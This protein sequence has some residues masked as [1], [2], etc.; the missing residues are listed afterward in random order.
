MVALDSEL[1][2]HAANGLL[3]AINYSASLQTPIFVPRNEH[4]FRL[5]LHSL[6]ISRDPGPNREAIKNLEDSVA[7]D[8]EYAPA[9]EEL[10]WR[11]YID[12]TYGDGGSQERTRGTECFKKLMQLDPN[13]TANQITIKTENGNLEGAYDEAADLL[14]RWPDKSGPHYEMS[15]VLR[16]AGLL[17]E[18]KKECAAALA[19]DPGYSAYR[20]CAI[21]F[22]LSGD[23]GG[24][25][26][27]IGLDQNT[28]F[29]AMLRL[30]IALRAGNGAA[31]LSQTGSASESGF[32]FA[33]VIRAFLGHARDPDL[34]R[35]IAEME[36]DPRLAQD[37]E[38]FYRNAEALAYIGRGDAALQQLRSAVHGNYCSYPALDTDPIFDPVRQNGQFSELRVAAIQC[39]QKLLNHRRDADTARTNQ[40]TQTQR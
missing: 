28:G 31:A 8:N 20:S 4:A 34:N 5:Y 14:H 32:L 26:Q 1:A 24:A 19:I 29:A 30:Q 9:W 12:Y 33:K 39:Q 10:A 6:A 35:A 16:Y 25:E 17:D 15:Y 27:Y 38:A 11:Y 40:K 37:S 22:V 23:Y 21:P 36:G 13:G 2:N 18:A 3:A 7:L